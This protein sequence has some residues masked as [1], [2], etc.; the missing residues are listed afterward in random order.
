MR[1]AGSA[2]HRTLTP[3]GAAGIAVVAVAGD[4]SDFLRAHW[5][6][7]LHPTRATHGKLIDGG[8]VLDDPLLVPV[9][10]GGGGFEL[11]LHGGPY[12]VRRTLELLT[13]AG[14]VA[15]SPPEPRTVEE[16]VAAALPRCAT[17][18]G[19]R[20]L[21][22]Q[23]RRYSLG[24]PA[25]DPTLR[26]MLT[27]A[28]VAI[29]GPP[30]VGKSTLANRLLGRDR[31]NVADAAGT[32]RDWGE[33]PAEL[34]GVP[35]VLT[36]TPGRRDTDDAIEAEAIGLSRPIVAAADVVVSVAVDGQ[37][38]PGDVRVVGKSDT[39]QRPGLRVSAVTGEGVDDLIDAV[40][41]ALDVDL[42]PHDRPL[43]F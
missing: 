42:T 18:A 39:H 6:G 38:L 19:V 12:I 10:G 1:Q 2:T 14:V 22:D 41:D 25:D 31:F 5:R 3:P 28:R 13:A 21:L 32:T 16:R 35:I 40:L 36:D 15:G 4:A 23:P 37:H 11:H 26:R 43:P 7:R 34:R 20:L 24:E 30:N 9:P 27:P 33:E 8:A 17:E 29:V